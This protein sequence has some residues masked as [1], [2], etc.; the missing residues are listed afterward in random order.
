MCALTNMD[1]QRWIQ[2]LQS[3]WSFMII[4]EMIDEKRA[5]VLGTHAGKVLLTLS[6]E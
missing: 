1:E 6:W 3:E 2:Q 5:S 4:R